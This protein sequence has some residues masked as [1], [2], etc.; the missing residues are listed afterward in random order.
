MLFYCRFKWHSGTRAEDVRRRVLEQHEAETHPGDKI[1]GWY[2]LAGGGSGF[3]LLEA[4]DAREVTEILQP[5]MDLLSWDVHPCYELNY[6]QA[7]GKFRQQLQAM[8]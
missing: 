3:V 7:I 5:Y 4:S 2:N 6:Q 1:K 8:A